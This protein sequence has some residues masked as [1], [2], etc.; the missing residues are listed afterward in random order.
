MLSSEIGVMRTRRKLTKTRMA[1]ISLAFRDKRAESPTRVA[2]TTISRY[3][4]VSHHYIYFVK[5]SLLLLNI[6]S[7]KIKFSR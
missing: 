1:G 5:D 4:S 2:T 3:I 6:K 7:D